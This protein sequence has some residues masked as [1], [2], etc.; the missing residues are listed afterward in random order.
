KR[1]FLQAALS[2]MN[3][4]DISFALAKLKIESTSVAEKLECLS[5]IQNSIYDI[6]MANSFVK[7]GGIAEVL[8]YIRDPDVD[9]R[10]QSIHIVAEMAQNNIFCQNYFLNEKLIAVIASTMNDSDEDLARGSIYAIS[11]LVQNFSPGLVEFL[12]INGLNTLLSCLSSTHASV[13]IKAAYLIGSLSSS[14]KSIKDR[15]KKD[16]AALSLFSNLEAKDEYDDK[17][18]ATLSALSALSA[19]SQWKISKS[20]YQRVE[21]I[22]KQ[23]IDSKELL[24]S[25]E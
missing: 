18:E 2:T 11:S 12:R 8:Q 19:N 10:P 23:I 24:E 15:I 9:L 16:N 13:Y 5:L 20:E 3:D 25:C 14:D 22:L 6:D 4:D 7:T 21:P 1:E 17:L